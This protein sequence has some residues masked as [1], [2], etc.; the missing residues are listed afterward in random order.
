[1]N[2]YRA[3]CWKE[4]TLRSSIDQSEIKRTKSVLFKVRTIVIVF[5]YDKYVP[6]IV[7]E[8]EATGQIDLID[9]QD[10]TWKYGTKADYDK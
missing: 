1:M 6:R 4:L 2:F 3:F 8:R 10:Q 5:E 9:P 7:I